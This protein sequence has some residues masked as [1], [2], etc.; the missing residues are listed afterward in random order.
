MKA[1]RLF[2]ALVGANGFVEPYLRAT[3][4]SRPMSLPTNINKGVKSM[5]DL[6]SL[7]IL[8][9][10]ACLTAGFGWSQAVNATL[11]GTVT[12]TTGAVVPNAKV[13]ATETN[14]SFVHNAQTN[15]SGNYIF[16]DLPPGIYSVSIEA[17]GFKR[18]SRPKIE[19]RVD[20]TVRVDAQLQP[21]SIT[22][23][24]EVTAAPPMLQTDSAETATKIDAVTLADTPVLSSNR[25]FQG[26]LNLAPGVAPVQE[27]HSQFF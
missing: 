15:E 27:Q 5:R 10:I 2:D 18:E 24:V 20:S 23:T 11:V 19:L 17:T 3:R 7:C 4:Q 1:T 21:G 9:V 8:I 13:V 6:R 25:N 22:E 26:L 12:D 16:P 14:T